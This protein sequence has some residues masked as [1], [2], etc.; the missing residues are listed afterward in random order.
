MFASNLISSFFP[1]TVSR[2]NENILLN[3]HFVQYYFLAFL[4]AYNLLPLLHSKRP[5][6]RK[7]FSYSNNIFRKTLLVKEC[8]VLGCRFLLSL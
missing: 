4:R 1:P 2:E 3:H 8:N 7:Q 6:L 5:L